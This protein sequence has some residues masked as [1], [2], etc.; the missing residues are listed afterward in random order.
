MHTLKV[1]EAVLHRN[2][3]NGIEFLFNNNTFTDRISTNTT[4]VDLVM[5]P[6]FII[7]R[8]DYYMARIVNIK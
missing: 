5:S 1:T 2:I 8:I 7:G 4:V 3:Q 6:V